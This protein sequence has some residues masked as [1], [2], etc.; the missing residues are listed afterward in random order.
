MSTQSNGCACPVCTGPECTCGCQ[1]AAY[2]VPSLR[3][4]GERAPYM[5]AGQFATL[6]QV[7]DH[8][9]RAPRASAGHSELT[10]LRLTTVEL[11]Q[12]EAFLRALSG[13]T[14]VNRAQ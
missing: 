11:Q 7:L 12:L 10:P 2:K 3:N 6:A 5:D 8:Y 14:L 4:V 13:P 9:N 1:N